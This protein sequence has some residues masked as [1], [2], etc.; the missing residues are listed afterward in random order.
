MVVV[1]HGQSNRRMDAA[2]RMYACMCTLAASTSTPSTHA[3][4]VHW[5]GAK[6]TTNAEQKTPTHRSNTSRNTNTLHRQ[7]GHGQRQRQ[8]ERDG[9]C[10]GIKTNPEVAGRE[11]SSS[12]SIFLYFSPYSFMNSGSSF[13]SAY[14]HVCQVTHMGVSLGCMRRVCFHFISIFNCKIC[15]QHSMIWYGMVWHGGMAWYGMVYVHMCRACNAK[16]VRLSVWLARVDTE[17]PPSRR[18]HAYALSASITRV[19][20]HARAALHTDWPE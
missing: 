10:V 5:Y 8:R 16:T 4:Y 13:C 17:A 6:Q 18:W 19:H 11:A 7:Q 12:I 3:L 14:V 15:E 1:V 2:F 9:G 20:H